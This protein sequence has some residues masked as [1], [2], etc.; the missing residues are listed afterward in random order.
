V[1]RAGKLVACCE[2]KSPRDDWLDDKL[3]QT[4]PFEIVGGAQHAALARSSR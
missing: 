1:F 3:A 4:Q 2:V